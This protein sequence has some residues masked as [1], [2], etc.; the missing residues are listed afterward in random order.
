MPSY[1]LIT[2]VDI[3][4]TQP[5]RDNTDTVLRAQQSNFNSLIQG[6]ELRANVMWNID[7]ERVVDSEGN[8]TWHWTF[9]V[10]QTGVYADQYSPIGLLLE[11][12]NNIPIINHLPTTPN[13]THPAFKT[14]GSDRNTWVILSE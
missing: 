9:F 10:E 2:E 8:S 6:V 13:L 4:R 7:P 5:N 1:K 12:L 11:D 3:T 14:K